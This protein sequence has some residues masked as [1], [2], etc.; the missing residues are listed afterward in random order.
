M[1]VRYGFVLVFGE[2]FFGLSRSL[3]PRM[4]ERDT[5]G[6][7]DYARKAITPRFYRVGKN[8]AATVIVS[9]GLGLRALG[10][11]RDDVLRCSRCFFFQFYF[12]VVVRARDEHLV[13]QSTPQTVFAEERE[14]RV[15]A[16][17]PTAHVRSWW[18]HVITYDCC[19]STEQ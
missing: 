4:G 13:S 3:L 2:S 8:A 15:R 16:V 9:T 12:H 17:D 6:T 14:R 7:S 19:V 5:C 18:S 11:Q 10:P 1:Y